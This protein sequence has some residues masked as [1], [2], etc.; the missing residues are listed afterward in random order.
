MSSVYGVATISSLLK[1]IGLFCRISSLLQ[2]S[3][4]KETYNC[5]KATNRS[6]PILT[7]ESIMDLDMCS[8][9]LKCLSTYGV[10][11]VRRIDKIVG[12]F[13]RMSFLL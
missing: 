4:A 8:N 1:I 9:V 7:Y 2:G 12:L 6:H 3:F 10:A 13:G 5:K 11:T